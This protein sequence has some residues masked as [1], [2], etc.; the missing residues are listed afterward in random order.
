MASCLY[1]EGQVDSAIAQL[2][3]S[4]KYDPKHAGTLFNLGLIKWKGKGDGAGAAA[5]WQKLLDLY[6]AIPSDLPNRETVEKLV[7]EA[8][9]H[10]GLK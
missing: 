6:P 7:A 2:N 4:L 9:Q 1:F 5:A 3:Q 10:P 8:R